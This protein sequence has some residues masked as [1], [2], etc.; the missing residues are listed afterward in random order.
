V[1]S[2]QSGS[3][4]MFYFRKSDQKLYVSRV[5]RKLD[6]LFS[7]LGGLFGILASFFGFVLINYNKC[8]YEL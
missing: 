7:Y 6:D 2:T 3:Y 8:C 5:Y 1:H 4:A